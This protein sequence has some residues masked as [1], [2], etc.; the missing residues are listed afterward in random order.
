MI[1]I[2]IPVY[3]TPK[4]DLERFL[5]SIIKQT[6]RNY[7]VYIIDDGSNDITKNYLDRHGVKYDGLFV[8]TG[9]KTDECIENGVKL[10]I[11]D[12]ES[13]CEDVSNAGIDVVLFTNLYNHAEN[14][15]VRKDNWTELYEYIKE[16]NNG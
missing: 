1:D 15:F 3:N 14:R 6:Y 4:I 11:D 5:N 7:K 2:I 9:T 13:H 12:K 8:N 16:K 10:F